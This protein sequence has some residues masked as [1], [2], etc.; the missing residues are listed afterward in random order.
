M[1]KGKKAQKGA[2]PVFFSICSRHKTLFIIMVSLVLIG[3]V[4][5]SIPFRAR[6]AFQNHNSY[7]ASYNIPAVPA[8]WEV[9]AGTL[10]DITGDALCEWV[11]VVWRPWRDWPTQKWLDTES[12]IRDF[13]D[14]HGLS[15][16]LVVL[17]PEDGSEIWVGSP[18]PHPIVKMVVGDVD[19]D[20]T[21]EVMTLRGDYEN[22]RRDTATHLDIWFWDD[23]GFTLKYRFPIKK[24]RN[25]PF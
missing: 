19:R 14:E 13:H 2:S 25:F 16:H 12:P 21:L 10:A 9:T 5:C 23:F 24:R 3:L 22:G 1:N 20:G 11:L 18:L 8:D 4:S 15:C 6:W 7:I 17:N